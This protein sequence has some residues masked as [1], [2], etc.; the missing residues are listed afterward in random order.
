MWI[1]TLATRQRAAATLRAYRRDLDE[2]GRDIAARL[3]VTVSALCLS[4][5][6]TD[7]LTL[8]LS[9]YQFREDQ[10]YTRRPPDPARAVRSPAAVARRTSALRGFL[11][12]AERTGRTPQDLGRYLEAPRSGRRLP[13]L[14][15]AELAVEAVEVAGR[16]ARWPERDQLIVALGLAC[17]MRRAEIA[18]LR[19]DR[20]DGAP[21]ERATVRGKGGKERVLGL[22]PLVTGLLAEYLPQRRRRLVTMGAAADTLIISTR[23]RDGEYG[24]RADATVETVIHVVDRTLRSL[25]ARRDGDLAHTLRHTFAATALREGV[26]NLREL[27]EALGHESLGTTQVYTHVTADE[28][29][30]AMRAHPL[31]RAPGP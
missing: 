27:Q 15:P 4:E 31:G 23:A 8:S 11:K 18:G 19:L 26:M 24:L 1:A 22:P 29:V 20:L 10:R 6:T 21:P 30:A 7:L 14:L 17:G 25:G 5:L 2:T 13:R 3:E 12:W 28:V 16:G 9:A